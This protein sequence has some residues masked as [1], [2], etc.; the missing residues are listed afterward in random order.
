MPPYLASQGLVIGHAGEVQVSMD[1]SEQVW[2]GGAVT[3][4]IQGTVEM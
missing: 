3:A 4:C 1:E 2:I